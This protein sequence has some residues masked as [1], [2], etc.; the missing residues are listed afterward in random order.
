MK[1]AA[2]ISPF[3]DI[4]WT[5]STDLPIDCASSSQAGMPAWAIWRMSWPLTL[6]VDR[7]WPSATISRFRP[8]A[9]RPSPDA[10]LPTSVRIGTT[11]S[12]ANP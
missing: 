7:I 1:V 5:S 8:S 12:A 3:R 6:P 4:F 9:P 11:C 10:A 2:A